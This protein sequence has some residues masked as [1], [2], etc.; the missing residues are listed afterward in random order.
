MNIQI[1]MVTF[2]SN[3][4]L[5]TLSVLPEKDI[6]KVIDKLRADVTLSSLPIETQPQ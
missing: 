3:P 2:L 6:K 1:K 4:E 5:V